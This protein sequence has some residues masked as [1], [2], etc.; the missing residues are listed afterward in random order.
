MAYNVLKGK[1][2]GSVDQY[3]DQEID[4]VK[5]FKNTISAS[6]FYDTDAQAPCVTTKDLPVKK[7]NGRTKNGLLTYQENSELK[8][9]HGLT[10]N[11]ETLQANKLKAKFIVGSAVH[12][13][14]IPANKFHEKI[15]AESINF[16]PGLH[17]VRKELQVKAI[18][19]LESSNE[20]IGISL[21]STSGL[22]IR[23]KNLVIDATK[24]LPI[25]SQGQNLS[26]QDLL[27]VS[28]ISRGTTNSTSLKNLYDNYIS[29]RIPKPS[30]NKNQIQFM[31]SGQF[32]SS[33][34]LTYDSSLNTLSIDG[35]IKSNNIKIDSEI[36]CNGAVYHNINKISDE[37]YHVRPEDYTIL[38]DASQ[39]KVKIILPPAVNNNGRV[40]II[41]K[42]N[43]D[44]YK[45][46]SNQIEV[47]CEEGSIDINDRITIKMNYSSRTLQ[48]DGE[49]WW[50]IGTKGS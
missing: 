10:Y 33:P 36:V 22:S 3:G 7:I 48:S 35:S 24:T 42:T 12:M 18:S 41:K 26:D 46:N 20:G 11:G 5:V 14:D 6:V 29:L 1:V 31:G 43:S 37:N 2:D 27:I 44:K 28:D 9:N 23:S 16:G 4:G 38:C 15:N 19:G 32:D 17:S 47:S 8:V 13:T 34:N 49:N 50:I 40:L 45:I 30:G 21:S 39:N 25:N